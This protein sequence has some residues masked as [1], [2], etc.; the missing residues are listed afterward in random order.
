VRRRSSLA[1]AAAAV[2]A[3]GVVGATWAAASPQ[4]APRESIIAAPTADELFDGSTSLEEVAEVASG[5]PGSIAPLCPDET[6]VHEPKSAGIQFGPCD[7]RPEGK[8]VLTRA[9]EGDDVSGSESCSAVLAKSGYGMSICGEGAEIV[10]LRAVD[11]RGG[12]LCMD[13]TY[14]PQVA[15]AE[16]R[17]VLCEGDVPSGG[18]PAVTGPAT[19]EQ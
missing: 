15:A 9:E 19:S 4:D 2:V 8:A 6:M 1:I 14:V 13:I 18:G 16:I 5:A 3:G 7:L 10:D 12:R 11:S 17:E